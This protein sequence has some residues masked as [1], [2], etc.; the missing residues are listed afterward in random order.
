MFAKLFSKITQ[1]LENYD[2]IIRIIQFAAI[3]ALNLVS[4]SLLL[5]HG[6][7][8]ILFFYSDSVKYWFRFDFR[9]DT[10]IKKYQAAM[11]LCQI[12]QTVSLHRRDK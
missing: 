10:V 5:F 12:F 1:C 6:L 2:E 11:F 3:Y 8:G 9:D 4:V 7:Y